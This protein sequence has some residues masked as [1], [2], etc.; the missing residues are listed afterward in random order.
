MRRDLN[1]SSFPSFA[2]KNSMKWNDLEYSRPSEKLSLKST[3]A[4]HPVDIRRTRMCAFT[5]ISMHPTELRDR[6]GRPNNPA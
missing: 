5:A 2:E 1:R 4:E 3:D 6:G